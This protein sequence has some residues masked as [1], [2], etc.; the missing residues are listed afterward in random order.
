MRVRGLCF[1]HA[2]HCKLL[3]HNE[4]QAAVGYPH[5]I[6]RT[7]V[8]GRVHLL[9]PL[10]AILLATAILLLA[11]VGGLPSGGSHKRGARRAVWCR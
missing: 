9:L 7:L 3:L 2:I 11:A 8:D 5:F 1:S 4:L 6:K 10:V